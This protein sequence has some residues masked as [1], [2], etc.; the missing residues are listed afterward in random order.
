[1]T[2][3]VHRGH[4][5]ALEV[6][7]VEFDDESVNIITENGNVL[8]FGF[9]SLACKLAISFFPSL[10]KFQVELVVSKPVRY[11]SGS[12]LPSPFVHLQPPTAG[13][14][15][16]SSICFDRHRHSHLQKFVVLLVQ[17]A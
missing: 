9:W 11:Y 8:A 16:G 1:M 10:L 6:V 14:D 5:L 7:M 2:A 15:N 4:F 17:L 12:P 13:N 3:T